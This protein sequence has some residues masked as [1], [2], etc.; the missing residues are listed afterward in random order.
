MSLSMPSYVSPTTGS[1]QVASSVGR[2]ADGRGDERIA[3][4]PTLWV[5]VMATGVVSHPGLADPLEAGQLAVAVQAV[6]AG[7]DR[8]AESD[9]AARA[10][11]RD[12]GADRALPTTSG[13]SPLDERRVADG[14]AGDVGDGVVGPRACP[15]RS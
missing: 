14:H 11:D 1:D 7:E 13:P 3:D 12:A 8:F 9:G 10:D 4:D 5:L 15:G 2:S 6:A